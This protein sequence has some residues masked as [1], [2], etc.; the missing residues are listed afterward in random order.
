VKKVHT[1]AAVDR[2]SQHDVEEVGEPLDAA[3]QR[4]RHIATRAYFKAE[5]RGFQPGKELDDWLEAEAE[6]DGWKQ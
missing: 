4:L 6:F 2:P 1:L 3:A 5:T